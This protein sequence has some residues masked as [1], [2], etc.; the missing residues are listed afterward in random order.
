MTLED[1]KDKSKVAKSK[2]KAL[3]E[4]SLNKSEK[5]K[6]KTVKKNLKTSSKKQKPTT[7]FVA[8]QSSLF[9]TNLSFRFSCKSYSM[10]NMFSDL[11]IVLYVGVVDENIETS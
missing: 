8:P 10:V 6:E 3:K 2:S 7:P 11:I 4:K 5:S 1:K 9:F